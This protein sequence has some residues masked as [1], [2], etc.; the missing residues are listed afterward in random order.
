M[1]SPPGGSAG[2]SR[3]SDPAASA[4]LETISSTARAALADVRLLLTQLR[5]SQGDGPQPTLADL[6]ALYAHVRAAGVQLRVDV[7]PAPPGTPPASVQLAVYRILQEALTNALRHGGGA[8]VSVRLRWLADRVELEV[9]NPASG[10]AA[11]VGGGHGLIGMRERAQL[12]GGRLDAG[13]EAGDFLVRATLPIEG[14]P[15]R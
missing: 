2:S 3:E 1:P 12:A 11:G 15:G 5:H 9:R 7:D 8:P 10:A 14:G 6:E 4:A 13:A